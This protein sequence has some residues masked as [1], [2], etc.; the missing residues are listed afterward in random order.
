MFCPLVYG[1]PI[2]VP[3]EDIDGKI[4]SE[5]VEMSAISKVSSKDLRTAEVMTGRIN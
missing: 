2:E 4:T 5:A 1:T 3:I